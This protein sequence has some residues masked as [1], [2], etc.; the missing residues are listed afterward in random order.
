MRLLARKPG[1]TREQFAVRWEESR[2]KFYRF[3]YCYVKNE[4]DAMEILSEAT[5]RAFCAMGT[6][7]DP[8]AFDTWMC[9]V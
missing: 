8:A 3:A 9:T 5:Y 2:E 4:H 6:L 1:M 7:R